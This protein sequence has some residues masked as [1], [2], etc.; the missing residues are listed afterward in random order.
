MT[1]HRYEN[2]STNRNLDALVQD[3]KSTETMRAILYASLKSPET[4]TRTDG[5]ETNL[6]LV[7][8]L[9]EN[10]NGDFTVYDG[11]FL[12]AQ[13][14]PRLAEVDHLLDVAQEIGNVYFS[15]RR[16]P[17]TSSITPDKAAF[18]L[19]GL[20]PLIKLTPS[21]RQRYLGLLTV[22]AH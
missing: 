22:A 16:A 20:G 11:L 9:V 7:A 5:P 4:L 1:F 13:R 2:S 17:F 6:P 8:A 10:A 21:T 19:L 18:T 12:T 14:L 3:I 15:E